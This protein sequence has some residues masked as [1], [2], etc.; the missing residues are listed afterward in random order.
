MNTSEIISF[1]NKSYEFVWIQGEEAPK[2]NVSQVSGYVFNERKEMLIVKSKN[3]TIPGGH[4]E[5]GETYIET[6]K[7]EV[8]EEGCVE[9]G[10]IEYLGYVKVTDQDT[11]DIKYQLRYVAKVSKVN[12]FYKK[13]EISERLFVN[14]KDLTKYIPWSSGKVFSQEVESAIASLV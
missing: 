13:F 12:E 7:R 6:L 14:P 5:K 4:L 1:G 3:W 2:D 10:N 11:K 9:I 8:D